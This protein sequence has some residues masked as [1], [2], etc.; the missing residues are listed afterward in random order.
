MIDESQLFKRIGE[1]P[2]DD[3]LRIVYGDSSKYRFETVVYAKAEIHKR[4]V[5]VDRARID[6]AVSA[7]CDKSPPGRPLKILAWLTSR[8]ATFAFG[9][10]GGLYYFVLVNYRSAEWEPGSHGALV[11]GWP[12]EFYRHGG[13]VASTHIDWLS[14][15]ANALIWL[16]VSIGAGFILTRIVGFIK[17]SMVE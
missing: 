8:A 4:G 14:L 17:S 12:L 16:A 15:L 7:S 11:A 1:L 6:R 3:L 2:D 13:Y 9:L 10:I 5:V